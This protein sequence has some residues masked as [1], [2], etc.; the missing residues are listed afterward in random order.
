MNTGK[1]RGSLLLVTVLIGTGGCAGGGSPAQTASPEGTVSPPAI[2][3]PAANSIAIKDFDYGAPVTVS[4]GTV[5][6]VTNADSAR[7][8]V[9]ADDGGTFAVEVAGNGGTATFTA[10]AT[11]GSYP[12]HCTYHPRMHGMLTVK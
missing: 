1:V 4:P 12:F 9:T 10:P 11:P 6:T 5:V 2:T 3:T 7:H 8:T